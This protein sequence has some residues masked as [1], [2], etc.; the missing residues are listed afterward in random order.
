VLGLL[1]AQF[2]S[3]PLNTDRRSVG[4][5]YGSYTVPRT[6][7]KRLTIGTGFRGQ[8]GTPINKLVSHPVYQ[9]RGEIPIG[10]RGIGGRLPST[11]QLDMHAD[12]PI[13]VG[14]KGKIKLAFDAFNVTDSRFTTNNNQFL[15]TGFQ[16]GLDPTFGTPTTFQRAF[17]GRGSIRYEF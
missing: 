3:G 13:S 8:S 11:L 2:Q 9:N 7:L 15:D 6:M 10:G 17:Y 12:Y 4:N 5:L 16:T 1:G 14:D